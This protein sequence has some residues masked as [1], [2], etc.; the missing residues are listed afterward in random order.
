MVLL[1]EEDCGG[2]ES[3][4]S[5]ALISFSLGES[6]LKPLTLR[7]ANVKGLSNISKAVPGG[8]RADRSRCSDGVP[9]Q[10]LLVTVIR[11]SVRAG[12]CVVVY[13]RGDQRHDV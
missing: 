4:A 11:L 5:H 7:E 8:W 1:N 6:P 2:G 12:E 13:P 10:V 3:K 9:C